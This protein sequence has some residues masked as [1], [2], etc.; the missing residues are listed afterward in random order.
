MS[1]R[2]QI[3]QMISKA[4]TSTEG[5]TSNPPAQDHN[6]TKGEE[7]QP[8][9]QNQQEAGQGVRMKAIE[10]CDKLAANPHDPKREFSDG[11]SY[12]ELRGQAR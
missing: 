5:M 6:V 10:R 3:P 9:E 2:S 8:D 11:V 4:P 12:S 7:I 1:F